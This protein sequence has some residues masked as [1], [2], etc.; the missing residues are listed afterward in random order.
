KKGLRLETGP[1]RPGMPWVMPVLPHDFVVPWGVKY[2][3]WSPWC[4]HRVIR[5]IDFLKSDVKYSDT[6]NLQPNRSMRDIVDSYMHTAPAKLKG[7][8][9]FAMP[10]R[11]S[12]NDVEFVELWEIHN[13]VTQEVITI[14]ETKVHR[15]DTD[16]LQVDGLPFKNLSFIRHPRSFWTTPQAEFLRFHQ[17]EQFDIA[18][19]GSKQRRINALKFLIREGTMHPDELVKALSPEVGI[20]AMMKQEADLSRDFA[21][22]PQ[23]SNFELWQEAEF[24]RRNARS[25]IG[26]SRNQM[27]EFD[28]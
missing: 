6:R 4:A 22:V 13:A 10:S 14:S 26:F 23:G 25:V 12:S 11:T 20:A 19:Q 5:H 24:G 8:R 15:K 18:L 28:A 3:Q 27:G 7:L 2:L 9:G 17:A 16:L 1:A 21:T